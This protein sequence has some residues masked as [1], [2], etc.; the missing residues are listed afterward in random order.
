MLDNYSPD[1]GCE[2]WLNSSILNNEIMPKNYKLYWRDRDDGYGGV[3][4]GIS[5]TLTSEHVDIDSLCEMCAVSIHLSHSQE[6]IVIGAYRPPSRD[7]TYQQNLCKCICDTVASRPNSFILFAG[8]FNVPDVQ[9]TGH[10]IVSH[11]YPIDINQ[12]VLKMVDDFYFTQLVN[13]PT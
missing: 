4:I 12:L 7:I 1:I 10:T 6:L 8:D 11:R 2:T 13:F 5:T 3:L 9:W